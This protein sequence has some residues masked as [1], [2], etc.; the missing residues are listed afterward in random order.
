MRDMLLKS[1]DQG[2]DSKRPYQEGSWDPKTDAHGSVGG[3]I[4]FT[5][6]SLLSLEVYYRHLPLYRR[7]MG[8]AP[9]EAAES[10]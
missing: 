8:I 5:S 9:K 1:Q 7:E 4:M 2:K 3:R 6:L 10:K